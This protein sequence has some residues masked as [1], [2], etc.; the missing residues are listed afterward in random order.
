MPMRQHAQRIRVYDERDVTGKRS[1]RLLLMYSE[2]VVT[3]IS[4]VYNVY[5]VLSSHRSSEPL[6]SAFRRAATCDYC[7]IR[8]QGL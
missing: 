6:L 3:S 4:A 8:V 5:D 1:F 2:S 7:N